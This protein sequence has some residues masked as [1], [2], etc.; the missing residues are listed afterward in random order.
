[1]TLKDI[2]K[3][4]IDKTFGRPYVWGAEGPFA[5]DCSGLVRFL[6]KDTQIF[7][8]FDQTADD[9]YRYL[10]SEEDAL[11]ARGLGS[12]AFFGSTRRIHHVGICIDELIMINASGG[13]AEITSIDI[14]L[15]KK[16]SVKIEPIDLRKDLVACI[17]PP[18]SKYG[19]KTD[20]DHW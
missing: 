7:P 15:S 17:K 20:S 5:F 3:R 4:A 12:L 11:N 9:M 10:L 13:G 14:A 16:A 1:M 2:Y 8:P 18:Y 19:I 6:L